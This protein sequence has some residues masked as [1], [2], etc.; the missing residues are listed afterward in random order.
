LSR[1]LSALSVLPRFYHRRI[2]SAANKT[3]CLFGYSNNF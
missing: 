1:A 2:V 3:M